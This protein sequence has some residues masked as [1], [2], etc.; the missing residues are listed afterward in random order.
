MV[1]PMAY[2]NVELCEERAVVVVLNGLFLVVCT[3]WV[4]DGASVASGG[5]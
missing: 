4:V 2:V 3:S 5:S 1:A